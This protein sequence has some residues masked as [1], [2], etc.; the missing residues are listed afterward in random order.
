VNDTTE[1]QMTFPFAWR[2]PQMEFDFMT[3]MPK[4]WPKRPG[5]EVRIIDLSILSP[6]ETDEIFEEICHGHCRDS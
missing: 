2:G 6:R 5:Q 1:H 3:T 4:V